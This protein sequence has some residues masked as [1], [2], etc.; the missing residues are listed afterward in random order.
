MTDIKPD[1]KRHKLLDMLPSSALF[2]S[3]GE[4]DN[5]YNPNTRKRKHSETLKLNKQ[6]YL[7]VPGPF[8]N[9]TASSC[10]FVAAVMYPIL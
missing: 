3:R 6:D 2:V 7:Y 1:W 10:E 4:L 5:Q 8:F 9:I